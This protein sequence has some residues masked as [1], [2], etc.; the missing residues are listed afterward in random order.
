MVSWAGTVITESEMTVRHQT[1]SD[2]I[3]SFSHSHQRQPLKTR[4]AFGNA[5]FCQPRLHFTDLLY[6]HLYGVLRTHKL[7]HWRVLS[8]HIVKKMYHWKI[9]LKLVSVDTVINESTQKHSFFKHGFY[10]AEIIMQIVS[11]VEKQFHD[12]RASLVFQAP[13]F[14]LGCFAL[15]FGVK[16]RYFLWRCSSSRDAGSF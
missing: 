7:I 16:R 4:T 11:S 1:I 5:N 2:Q 3:I 10:Y 15:A 6:V 13:C 12:L 9:A 8:I 14:N